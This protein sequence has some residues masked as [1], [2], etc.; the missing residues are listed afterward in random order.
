MAE[1]QLINTISQMQS[2]DSRNIPSQMIPNP[3]GG[4]V[5]T[6]Q[7][8]SGK[9]LPQPPN[10][11]L[12]EAETE[13]GANSRVQQPAR[14][15]LLPFPSWV[16]PTRRSKMDEDLLKLFRKVE[17][18]IL[19]LNAIKQVPKYAKFHKELYIH[20]R[21]KI[22]GAVETRGIVSALVKREDAS[23]GIQ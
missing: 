14:V 5:G 11:R 23:V 3:K 6:V 19:L 4:G 18:N 17:I 15:V 10:P 1:R 21:K 22:K 8:R 20:K 12:A 16:V 13:P 9:E 7:L 2:V